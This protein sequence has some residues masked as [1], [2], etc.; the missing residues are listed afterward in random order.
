MRIPKKEVELA[1]N[2]ISKSLTVVEHP[3]GWTTE[4]ILWTVTPVRLP[5]WSIIFQ[6]TH[7][8]ELTLR[9]LLLKLIFDRI[10]KNEAKVLTMLVV[11]EPPETYD[12]LMLILSNQQR[13][14]NVREKLLQLMSSNQF[15]GITDPRRDYRSY[16][17][18]MFV[19]K[20]W[21]AETRIPPK[22]YIG[23][24]YNDHGTLSTAP[25]WKDQLTDD[26]EE[27]PRLCV[28]H[29]LLKQLFELPLYRSSSFRGAIRLTSS[30]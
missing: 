17:P 4:R 22:R 29:Y 19:F 8:R 24:G 25:S 2:G 26:G 14:I 5:G 12:I 28:L 9:H 18:Q 10:N 15:L 11:A 13:I 21:T 16:S 1:I 27:T 30:K 6:S 20:M 23:I 7:T 3:S